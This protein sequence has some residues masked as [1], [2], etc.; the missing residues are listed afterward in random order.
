MWG[1]MHHNRTA[2]AAMD[3]RGPNSIVQ[4]TSSDMAY[5]GGRCLQKMIWKRY[6]SKGKD[7]SLKQNN[8]V[9][10]SSEMMCKIK[11]LPES[12]YLV[13]HA[14]TTAVHLDCEKVYDW[15]LN[16][17]LE[18]E[19]EIGFTLGDMKK[20]DFTEHGLK[21][22]LESQIPFAEK[23]LKHKFKKKT[24]DKLWK[25]WGSVKIRRRKELQQVDVI[26]RTDIL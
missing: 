17:G 2:H 7:F 8:A 11:D 13:E 16:I 21:N 14:L 10:D 15:K 24:I 3:R 19:I 18:I 1:Y 25:K 5:I 9:H 4:G 6:H 26:E 20:W 23:E 12:L 22:I